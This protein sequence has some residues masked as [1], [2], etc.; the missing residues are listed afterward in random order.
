MN[1]EEALPLLREGRVCVSCAGYRWR[2]R[3][4]MLERQ[5]LG[6]GFWQRHAPN[7]DSVYTLVEEALPIPKQDPPT[8]LSCHYWRS[9]R[10]LVL[11]AKAWVEECCPLE[12][13]MTSAQYRLKAAADDF[14][15]PE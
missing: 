5:S 10:R 3:A 8:H 6:G 7:V 12:S 15:D 2:V 9:L 14:E 11:A 13:S 1:L 4:S